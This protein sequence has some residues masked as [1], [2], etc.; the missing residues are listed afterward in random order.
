M[1]NLALDAVQ[2][3]LDG[4]TGSGEMLEG[5][6]LVRVGDIAPIPDRLMPAITIDWEEDSVGPLSGGRQQTGRAEHGFG[7][8]VTLYTYS[9]SKNDTASRSLRDLWIRSESGQLLGLKPALLQLQRQGIRDVDSGTT[10]TFR[11]GR[12]RP[13]IR[14]EGGHFTAGCSTE[15]T[16]ITWGPTP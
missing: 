8:A 9:L 4:L 2:N 5:V 14:R 16:A 6:K 3:Y 7:L 13:G 15:L 1:L 11:L 12:T 10:F